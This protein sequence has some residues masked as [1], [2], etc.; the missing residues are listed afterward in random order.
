L[1]DEFFKEN[2][3]KHCGDVIFPDPLK[4]QGS[5]CKINQFPVTFSNQYSINHSQYWL[6]G[7]NAMQNCDKRAINQNV[8]QRQNSLSENCDFE[9][10]LQIIGNYETMFSKIMCASI[11]NRRHFLAGCLDCG[12][13]A[14][15]KIEIEQLEEMQARKLQTL[16]R[17]VG[18]DCLIC[19]DSEDLLKLVFPLSQISGLP[20]V[21]VKNDD[22]NNQVE[23][24]SKSTVNIDN[25][26]FPIEITYEQEQGLYFGFQLGM[27]R[28]DKKEVNEMKIPLNDLTKMLN[29][30]EII[31]S[32]SEMNVSE[33]RHPGRFLLGDLTIT[34]NVC[35]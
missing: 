4:Y 20:S 23:T 3:S 22:A 17:S 32:N 10:T 13:L 31:P 2:R 8:K 18:V 11:E 29:S 34:H 5:W 19:H 16:S 7:L 27:F 9:R 35:H 15:L 6:L 12:N 25:Y 26:H 24:F 14:N 21:L 1:F 33:Q 28:E 30:G